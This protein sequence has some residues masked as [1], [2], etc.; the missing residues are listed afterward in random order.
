VRTADTP[1]EVEDYC[2]WFGDARDSVLYF[3]AA[4]FWST[5]RDAGGDPR[6]DLRNTGPQ[7]VGRFDLTRLE[8]QEPL[9]VGGPEARSGV[10]DV[11]AHPNGRIYFT[12][13]FEPAGYVEPTSGRVRRFEAAGPGL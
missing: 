6:A 1:S 8:F 2:A 4:A 7:F 5:S 3:G 12:T 13:Y 9:A 10:W 11:L